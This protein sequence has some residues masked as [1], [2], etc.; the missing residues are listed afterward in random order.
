MHNSSHHSSQ[1]ISEEFNEEKDKFGM[2][3][4]LKKLVQQKYEIVQLVGRGSYGFV[5]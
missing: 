3:D 5:S 1:K 2:T 4:K